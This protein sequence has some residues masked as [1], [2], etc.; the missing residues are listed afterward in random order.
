MR[1]HVTSPA[2]VVPRVGVLGLFGTDRR[3]SCAALD[4]PIKARAAR[5]TNPFPMM[6][7]RSAGVRDH[8]AVVQPGADW[9]EEI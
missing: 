2:G 7:S 8:Y 4:G 1:G 6:S 5:P 9:P 3:R